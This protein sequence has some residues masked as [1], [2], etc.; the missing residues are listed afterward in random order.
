MGCAPWKKKTPLPPRSPQQ[1]GPRGGAFNWSPKVRI[2]QLSITEIMKNYLLFD[3]D[4]EK[5]QHGKSDSW[6]YEMRLN[7]ES[8]GES[9]KGKFKQALEEVSHLSPKNSGIWICKLGVGENEKDFCKD[10]RMKED[11]GT[12][13]FLSF[14]THHFVSTLGSRVLEGQAVEQHAGSSTKHVLAS[15][16]GRWKLSM[17]LGSCSTSE[18]IESWKTT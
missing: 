17:N 13:H 18:R 1:I 15:R 9:L 2:P 8:K 5:I 3:V 14:S 6:S 12:L 7:L 11:I 4:L 10:S 16:T